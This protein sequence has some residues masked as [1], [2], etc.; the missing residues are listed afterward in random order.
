MHRIPGIPSHD[1][2]AT[3]NSGARASRAHAAARTTA[4]AT[5]HPSLQNR[6]SHHDDPKVL[7]R[8]QRFI[9][10]LFGRD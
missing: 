6:S 9:G 2:A 4:H 7:V 3:L 10:R 8:W 1:E 5:P